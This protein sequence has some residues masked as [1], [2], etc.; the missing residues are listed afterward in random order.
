MNSILNNRI[1]IMKLL[2]NLFFPLALVAACS[3]NTPDE[4]GDK[5][6]KKEDKIVGVVSE[7]DIFIGDHYSG[8]NEG[9]HTFR[10]PAVVK[11]TKG[12]ILAFCEGRR[13]GGGDSGD[14]DLVLRR[15]ADGGKT[16][17]KIQIVWNDG[18]NTCGNPCPVVDPETGRI[19]MLMTWNLGTDKAASDFNNGLTKDTRRAYYTY[20][21]DDGKTWSKA[22][23]I[24]SEVKK[25]E[26]GWYATGPCHAIVL[27]NGEHKG[28]LLF[29]CD[30]N[31]RKAVTGATTGYS[32][33]VYSDDKGA[34]WHIGGQVKG[35]NECSVAELSDGR[36]FMSC[37]TSSGK[38]LLAWSSDGGETFGP[39]ENCAALPDPKC[40]GSV[41]STVWNGTHYVFHSNCSDA[42][43][44]VSMKVKASADGGKTWS[45]GYPLPAPHVAY[46]DMVM[47]TDNILALFYENG[48]NG[49]Y[50]RISFQRIGVSYIIKNQQ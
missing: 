47:T 43:A 37:R 13:N 41:L 16:W 6:G 3:G 25:D 46:S 18:S 7:P 14:I 15:S 34:T 38:R 45:S 28:R 50:E 21:D 1:G 5:P 10:I 29:P 32:L 26:W 36:V 35:G 24:T 9:F 11:S 17:G 49:S 19:H 33:V 20:S 42:S 30:A 40:Q 31:E 48:D 4:P 23:E 12:T 39:S 27:Q 2:Y 22:R 44:R 8:G